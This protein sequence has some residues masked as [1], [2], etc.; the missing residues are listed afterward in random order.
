MITVK[1]LDVRISDNEPQAENNETYR[2]F[3]RTS[4]DEFGMEPRDIDNMTDKELDTYF[5]FLDYLWDK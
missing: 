4:E 1:H 2:N 3:I 5:E